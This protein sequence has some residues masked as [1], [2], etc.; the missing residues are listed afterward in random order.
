[1]ETGIPTLKI[2]PVLV[3]YGSETL[4]KGGKFPVQFSKDGHAEADITCL[5][6]E[7]A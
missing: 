4:F 6:E 1:M 5:Y 3:Q 7:A 2:V